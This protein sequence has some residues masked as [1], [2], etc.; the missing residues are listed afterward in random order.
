ME[1]HIKMTNGEINEA[2]EILVEIVNSIS[3]G[4]KSYNPKFSYLVGRNLRIL[5]VEN[6]DFVEAKQELIQNFGEFKRDDVTGREYYA[7]NKEDRSQFA[8]YRSRANELANLEH[9]ITV[10]AVDAYDLH[11]W[12]IP[13]E[14]E[15][16]LWFLVDEDSLEE[17]Y[18]ACEACE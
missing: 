11:S 3:R 9:T 6:A 17:E 13:F 15:S 7:V 12:G 18:D 1:K 10:Y 5:R 14:I 8:E 16:L 2:V 4:G